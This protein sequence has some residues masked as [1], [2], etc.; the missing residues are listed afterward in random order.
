MTAIT[1]QLT[2]LEQQRLTTLEAATPEPVQLDLLPLIEATTVE[3]VAS[4]QPT[5]SRILT[6]GT[7]EI[8]GEPCW[9]HY[10][11]SDSERKSCYVAHHANGSICVRE[12]FR[13]PERHPIP[14]I[15]TRCDV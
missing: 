15:P 8:C 14:S 10:R 5:A 11:Y 12:V 2:M 1:E 7:C 4:E 6:P 13:H 3:E 9:D